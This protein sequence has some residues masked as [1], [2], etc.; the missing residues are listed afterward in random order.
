MR[1][2]KSEKGGRV[3]G[4]VFVVD[5]ESSKNNPLTGTVGKDKK[6][7]TKVF[8]VEWDK[9]VGILSAGEDCRVQINRG[10]DGG[11]AKE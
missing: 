9:S 8:G 2:S 3:G 4:S 10:V 11:S 6:G 5:R 7:K 1:A